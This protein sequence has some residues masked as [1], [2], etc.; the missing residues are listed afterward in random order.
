MLFAAV[1][2]G[3]QCG[4]KTTI[5]LKPYAVPVPTA[6]SVFMSAEK[7]LASFQA[8]EKNRFPG[9]MM[10]VLVAR[11]R[12]L[13]TSSIE[14]GDERMNQSVMLIILM[15]IIGTVSVALKRKSALSLR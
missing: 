1:A 4:N 13:F 2:L 3:S 10:T 6:T 5:V 15:I 14:R 12:S 9:S 11:N 8:V 7:C